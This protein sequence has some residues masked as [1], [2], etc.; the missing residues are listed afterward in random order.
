MLPSSIAVDRSFLTSCGIATLRYAAVPPRSPAHLAAAR[1]EDAAHRGPQRHER[2]SPRS[3]K[4]VAG[5]GAPARA[6]LT[7][8]SKF[9]SPD[10]K[11]NVTPD[12]PRRCCW[13][14]RA[15][16]AG[17]DRN[18]QPEP[19]AQSVDSGVSPVRKQ[20]APHQTESR[21]VCWVQ[22]S[23]SRPRVAI[24]PGIRRGG[25][26]ERSRRWRQSGAAPC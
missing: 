17:R 16:E 8:R 12:A 5:D 25:K 14:T 18:G 11:H 6:G 23:N 1:G 3:P 9:R 13:P 24:T 22:Q 2:V 20:V 26:R 10:L 21:L 15:V 7:W 4:G 19:I